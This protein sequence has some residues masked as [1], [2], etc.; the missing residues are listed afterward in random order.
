MR[1]RGV[2]GAI[3]EFY[4]QQ[5]RDSVR[6][7]SYIRRESAEFDQVLE[8]ADHRAEKGLDGG[9]STKEESNECNGDSIDVSM[10]SDLT[11]AGR[12]ILAIVSR[13]IK[14]GELETRDI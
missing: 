4:S 5:P 7:T 10:I 2:A 1:K 14:P 8:F 13:N 9:E 6:L 11:K 12:A 3:C